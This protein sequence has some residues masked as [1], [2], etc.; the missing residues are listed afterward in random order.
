M[1]MEFF[2]WDWMNLFFEED[3]EKFKFYH[4]STSVMTIPYFAVVDEFQHFVYENP[5]VTPEERK[6]FWRELERTYFPSRTYEEN[7]YLDR[8]G[9]W[10]QQLHIFNYPF[11]YIDY[12]LAQV[13]A[14]QFWTKI[15][16]DKE[17]AWKDY[18]RLCQLGGSRS[19]VELVQAANLRS[20]FDENCIESMIGDIASWLHSI[21]DK[22]L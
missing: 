17:Q 10:H 20:P 18:L 12:G 15:Q 13:C 4:L 22:S 9:F 21:D 8:G 11:Y 3:T 5:S 6:S 19:F 16:S 2:T 7:K 1:S 14:L